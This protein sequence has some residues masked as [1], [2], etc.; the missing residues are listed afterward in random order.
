MTKNF[1]LVLF[2]S[3]FCLASETSTFQLLGKPVKFFNY[4]EQHITVSK[5]CDLLKTKNEFCED[6]KFLKTISLSKAGLQGTGGVN[7]SSIICSETLKGKVYV[8][9]DENKNE[10]SFC[11]LPSGFYIDGGTI[12]YYAVENEGI[13]QSPRGKSRFKK[14]K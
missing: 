5:S 12:T 11:L 7:A 8:G 14:A 3:E 2:I 9:F 1:L 10:N 4:P 13:K 6:L